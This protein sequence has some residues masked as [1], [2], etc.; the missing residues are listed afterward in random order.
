[1]KLRASSFS[2]SKSIL[3]AGDFRMIWLFHYSFYGANIAAVH[4]LSS[5]RAPLVALKMHLVFDGLERWIVCSRARWASA[6][7]R[8]SRVRKKGKIDDD[9]ASRETSKVKRCCWSR[10]LRICKRLTRAHTSMW[11]VRLQSNGIRISI[12][13]GEFS[14]CCCCLPEQKLRVTSYSRLSSN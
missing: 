7:L 4:S 13:D 11:L 5:H 6:P 12:F 3:S 2:Q 10:K 9:L 14:C 1:M 8:I